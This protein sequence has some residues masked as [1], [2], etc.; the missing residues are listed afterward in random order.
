MTVTACKAIWF[1]CEQCCHGQFA[2]YTLDSDWEE[3]RAVMADTIDCERCDHPNRVI[4]E[5]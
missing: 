1:E 4:E 3:D 2:D 5:L